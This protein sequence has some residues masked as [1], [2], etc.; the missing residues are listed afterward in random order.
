MPLHSST[1]NG[2]WLSRERVVAFC[3]LCLCN[4]GKVAVRPIFFLL[5][6]SQV[7]GKEG[8]IKLMMKTAH[9]NNGGLICHKPAV[10][11]SALS[12]LTLRTFHF[13]FCSRT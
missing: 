1:V 10:K 7:K 13:W 8:M 6:L 11:A 2:L 9:A 4:N 12:H 3:F 5:V